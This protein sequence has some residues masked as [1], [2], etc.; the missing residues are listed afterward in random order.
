MYHNLHVLPPPSYYD[1]RRRDDDAAL[2]GNVGA[3]SRP[4]KK[5]EA[6]DNF[7]KVGHSPVK[8]ANSHSS[9]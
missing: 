4:K 2:V 3:R 9:R 6:I 8:R 1:E 5:V 7:T